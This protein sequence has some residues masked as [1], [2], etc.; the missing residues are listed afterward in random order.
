[1]TN[2]CSH[3]AVV[4]ASARAAVQSVLR[5]GRSA[6]AADL[7]ADMDLR[8]MCQVTRISDYPKELV[9]W[10]RRT[11][12]DGWLYT[13]AL[14]NH[15]DLIDQLASI[16]PLLG[17]SGSKLRRVRDPLVLKQ[18]LNAH[19]LSFPD[20][21]K[22]NVGLPHNG[23]WLA[24]TYS[25]SSGIGVSALIAQSRGYCQRRINGEAGSA[26][27]ATGTLLAITQQLAGEEWTGAAPFQ[28]CGSVA[29]W[30]LPTRAQQQLHKLGEVLEEEF[31]LEGLFG[32]D[33]VFDGHDVWPVEVNPR[34]TAAVEVVERAS[35]LKLI[36]WHLADRNELPF[37]PLLET[38]GSVLHGKAIWFAK[39][40]VDITNE[41]ANWALSQTD[42]ADI[43]RA[44]SQIPIGRPVLTIRAEGDTSPAVLRLLK[45]RVAE[46]EQLTA[47]GVGACDWG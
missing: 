42:L 30:S 2:T 32:V 25:S 21:C 40:E 22:S 45:E 18:T 9:D 20:T 31:G 39:Q 3:I 46:L 16:C 6:V 13:G 29:P 43:P 12:C 28:Y 41:F 7:F 11:E 35:R 23:S 10:L 47:K 5:S 15:P 36:D 26:V 37:S 44:G 1:M 8:R 27:F 38:G 34:Y 33:F 4:G 17:V 19:G 14:E 24:K